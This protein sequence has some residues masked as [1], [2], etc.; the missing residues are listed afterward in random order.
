M[1]IACGARAQY[2]TDTRV[3]FVT[4][5]ENSVRKQN[6]AVLQFFVLFCF[7]P[8]LFSALESVMELLGPLSR[9]DL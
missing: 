1:S 8:F 6:V 7:V 2:S 9:C 5:S 4:R 3:A